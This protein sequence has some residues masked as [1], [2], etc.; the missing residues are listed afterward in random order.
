MNSSTKGMLFLAFKNLNDA[1]GDFLNGTKI[2]SI[3][4]TVNTF[5]I[6]AAVLGAA[7][8][9]MPGAGGILAALAQTGL[10][11]ALYV[12]INKTLGISISEHTIKFVGSAIATN[13]ITNAG[14]MILAYAAAA[15]MS[16]IPIF[17]QAGSAVTHLALG[18]ILIYASAVI[19]LNFL[20]STFKAKGSFSFDDSEE[21]EKTI[22]D[23]VKN[24]DIKEIIKEGKN[25]FKE[26]K[27]NGDIARAQ[28]AMECPRCNHEITPNQKYCSNCGLLLIP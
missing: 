8:D 10:V 12:K 15:V 1:A 14:Y 7:S 24:S 28:K 2:E 17:G 4:D 27:D 3:K 21:T 23:T 6:S 11:W 5:A 18:Y 20:T 9:I 26:A 19:Y 13:L 25:A 16:F 22:Q